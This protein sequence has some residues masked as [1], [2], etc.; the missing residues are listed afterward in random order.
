M[1]YLNLY[2]KDLVI[3]CRDN[4]SFILDDIYALHKS[5]RMSRIY[6]LKKILYCGNSLAVL[7]AVVWKCYTFFDILA[8]YFQRISSG[9]LLARLWGDYKHSPNLFSHHI[10]DLTCV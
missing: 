10:L 3:L 6:T 4:L 9:E 1:L 5:M 7:V 8:L 2:L